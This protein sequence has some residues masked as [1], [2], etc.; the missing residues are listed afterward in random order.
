MMDVKNSRA[1]VIGLGASGAAAACLLQ[2]RGA[3]RVTVVDAADHE[4]LQAAAKPLQSRGITVR[5]RVSELPSEPFDFAV[6]SP[7]VPSRKGVAQQVRDRQITL[8]GELELGY[9]CY[10]S[11]PVVAITGTNGKTT[12]T[13]LMERVLLKAGKRTVAAGNIGLPLCELARTQPDLDVLTLEVSSFQLE[14]TLHFRP[15]LAVIL[16]FTPDHF[17]RYAGMDDYVR[18]KARLCVQQ[19]DTDWVVIQYDALQYLEK[20]GI[21][22]RGRRLT[23]GAEDAPADFFLSAGKIFR[24]HDTGVR[25]I[26]SMEQTRLRGPH[27]A[28][29]IMAIFAAGEAMQLPHTSIIEALA[30]YIPAAH[31]CELVAE[32]HGILFYNDS[33]ATNVDAVAKA[34][35]TMPVGPEGERNVWLIAGGKD[36]GFSYEALGP[37]LARRVKG[38]FLIGET[39]ARLA[40]AWSHFVPCTAAATLIEAVNETARRAIRGDVILLS[41]ACSSFDMFRDYQHRGEVFRQAVSSCVQARRSEASSSPPEFQAQLNEPVKSDFELHKPV[42]TKQP[43]LNLLNAEKLTSAR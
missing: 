16:N 6:I 30:E 31:R 35:S 29:N 3:S 7:G 5:L 14:T 25:Q 11:C 22:A 1:L 40:G 27:N 24:R 15:Q 23:F 17:D 41:P 21:Q 36:K 8:L 9:Q 19:E 32:D 20:L 18:T 33:K 13:E 37:W 42:I 2:E 39:R 28:E 26:F 10:R 12:T 4:R 43:G 38:A 34:L